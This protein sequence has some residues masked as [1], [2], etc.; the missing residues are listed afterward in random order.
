MKFDPIR[1]LADMRHE[2][3]EHGG[4][5]MSVETSTTFTVMD[6]ATMP[7]IFRGQR[8][9]DHGG[10]YLYGRHFNPTVYVLGRQIAALEG[11]A[12]GYC[13]ASGMGA[14]SATIHQLCNAGDHIVSSDTVY[15]GTF[16]LFHEYM[17]AKSG[18]NVSFVDTSDLDAVAA[19]INE[20]TRVLYVETLANPTLRV[21]DIPALARLA[22]A[23]GIKLVVDNTFSPLIVS[24]IQLGADVVIHSLTKFMNG[25]S[26]IVAGSISGTTEFVASLMDLHQGSLMLLGPTLDPRVAYDISMRLPHLGLR[27]AEHSRRAHEFAHRLQDM[28]VRTI[29]PGLKNHPDHALLKEIGNEAYGA[30]G[31]FCIDMGVRSR[32]YELMDRLQNK[33]G[34][35]YMAVSLGYFD[36]LM[37]TPASSTSSEIPDEH[38]ASIGV[39][40]GLVRMSIGYTGTLEQRWRQLATVLQEMGIA[41]VTSAY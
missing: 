38:R 19:A 28:G 14:I 5:N 35:G 20:Y 26:D 30:G 13:T 25:A 27:M 1:S 23:N 29:Y 8:S 41:A 40:P 6:P 33:H 36:T 18:V 10:C 34:F 32:A 2:F 7:E 37:S 15:G 31:V 4:V 22:R 3:G 17:P 9:P 12:A 16:A 11:A 39:S 21:A 24:P